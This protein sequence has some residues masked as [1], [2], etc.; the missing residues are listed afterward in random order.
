V[1]DGAGRF[2]VGTWLYGGVND[3]PI[4]QSRAKSER[5]N[6]ILRLGQD[7]IL[8]VPS[9]LLF[10]HRRALPLVRGRM[11]AGGK[12]RQLQFK[13]GRPDRGRIIS[14]GGFLTRNGPIK[15]KRGNIWR[16]LWVSA[17]LLLLPPLA[18]AAGVVVLGSYSSDG[19]GSGPLQSTAETTITK[20]VSLAERPDESS[21]GGQPPIAKDPS[22]YDA[23]VGET[24]DGPAVAKK[25]PTR[26]YGSIPVALVHVWKSREQS[27]MAD[28]DAAPSTFAAA[29]PSSAASHIHAS[30]A[31]RRMGRHEPR[32]VYRVKQARARAHDEPR[33]MAGTHPPLRV[34]GRRR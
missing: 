24:A 7:R 23:P 3:G 5:G 14:N 17:G 16:Q 33:L 34:G 1:E 13:A 15:R 25:D 32:S 20:S 10:S 11:D 18:M 6:E 19:H 30:H 2:M 26:Y 28:I 31:S 22:R 27:A 8:I 4:D 29:R 12:T 21:V 9:R